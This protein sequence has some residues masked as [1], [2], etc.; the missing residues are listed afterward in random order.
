[1]NF[2]KMHGLGNDFII[3][4]YFAGDL[5]DDTE[6]SNMAVKLCDRHT[7]IG[8]DGLVLVVPSEK[9]DAGMRIFN[10]DGSEPSMCGNAI[11]FFARYLYETGMVSGKSFRRS[12]FLIR[13]ICYAVLG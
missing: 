9:A 1:M 3:L 11:R 5:P 2:V 4:D 7:G 10:P 6:C 12:V 8:A 13:R